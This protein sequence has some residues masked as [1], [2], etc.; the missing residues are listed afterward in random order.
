VDV[1][2]YIDPKTEQPHIYRHGVGES[3]SKT[4]FGGPWRIDPGERDHASRWVEHAR[5]GTSA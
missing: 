4:C 2:Y 3:E 5:D 1:R